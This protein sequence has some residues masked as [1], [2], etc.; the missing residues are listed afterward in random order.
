MH[1]NCKVQQKWKEDLKGHGFF[2]HGSNWSIEQHVCTARI[3]W[4]K[5]KKYLIIEGDLLVD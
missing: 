5:S 1:S 2:S 3:V 4:Y